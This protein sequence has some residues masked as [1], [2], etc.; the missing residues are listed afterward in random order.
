MRRHET[1]FASLIAGVVF[2]AAGILALA[3]GSDRF[4]DVIVWV[5]PAVLLGLGAA[6][7]VRSARENR[8]S[9]EV[10]SEGGEYREVEEPGRSHDG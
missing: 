4:A 1:D 6:L 2:A 10:S 9:Y 8:P 5:W 7:L 3:A